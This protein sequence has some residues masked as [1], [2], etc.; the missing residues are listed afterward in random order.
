MEKQT[1]EEYEQK[2]TDALEAFRNFLKECS[3]KNFTVQQ[4]LMIGTFAEEE[5][6]R[7]VAN[8]Q[9]QTTVTE[10]QCDLHQHNLKNREVRKMDKKIV[11]AMKNFAIRTL[12]GDGDIHPRSGYITGSP[13]NIKR[14]AGRQPAGRKIKLIFSK[15]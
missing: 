8:V 14:P 6:K 13:E 15:Y 9:I 7:I 2:R 1:F 5:I 10:D 11:E 12:N 4:F 3:K